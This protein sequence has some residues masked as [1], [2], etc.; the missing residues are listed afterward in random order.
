[1]LLRS[2]LGGSLMVALLALVLGGAEA[3]ANLIAFE[4]WSRQGD[5]LK[6]MDESGTQVRQLH[7]GALRYMSISPPGPAGETWVAFTDGD[8]DIGMGGALYM[9][10]ADGGRVL[11]TC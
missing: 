4:V 8:Q 1:M 11:C 10:S 5:D 7:R 9:I 2:H 6:V 3:S